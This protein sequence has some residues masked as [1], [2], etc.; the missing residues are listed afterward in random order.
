[1]RKPCLNFRLRMLVIVG[2]LLVSL[3]R[4]LGVGMVMRSR[5]RIVGVRRIDCSV[6]AVMLMLVFVRMLV[7]VS[8]R[9]AVHHVVV[10]VQVVVHMLVEMDMFMRVRPSRLVDL[11]PGDVLHPRLWPSRVVGD[12]ARA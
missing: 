8:A 11:A 2:R 9:M 5:R 10:G 4:Q 7:P 6:Q 3:A 1:M 12:Q